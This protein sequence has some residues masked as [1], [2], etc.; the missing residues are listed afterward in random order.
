MEAR[1]EAENRRSWLDQYAKLTNRESLSLA[2]AGL[3]GTQHAIV[4]YLLAQTRGTGRMQSGE[5]AGASHDDWG[6]ARDSFA[7]ESRHIFR[8]WIAAGIGRHEKTVERE[9]RRLI[10]CG[11]VRELEPARREH[12]AVLALDLDEAHWSLNAD[13]RADS[14]TKQGPA[15]GFGER[16]RPSE[17]AHLT[18]SRGS[19]SAD[20]SSE[21]VSEDAPPCAEPVSVSAPPLEET[22]E[23][24]PPEARPEEETSADGPLRGPSTDAS[25]SMERLTVPEIRRLAARLVAGRR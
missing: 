19:A 8:G 20:A 13:K 17:S 24:R 25:F 15:E 9:L 10:A 14:L 16:F 18:P 5:L 2:R 7:C 6:D 11:I 12:A 23:A 4:L 22:F 21:K 3:N 1:P